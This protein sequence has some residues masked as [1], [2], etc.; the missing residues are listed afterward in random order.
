ME[1]CPGFGGADCAGSGVEIERVERVGAGGGDG[2][3]LCVGGERGGE[4]E[5][6]VGLVWRRSQKGDE[7]GDQ[8]DRGGDAGDPGGLCSGAS[9][10]RGGGRR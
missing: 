1:H 10:G 4:G 9:A 8:K 3:D 5:G 7:A 6:V 2:N